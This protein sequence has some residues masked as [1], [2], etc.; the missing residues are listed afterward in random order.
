MRVQHSEPTGIAWRGDGGIVRREAAPQL[1][2]PDAP[3]G[4]SGDQLLHARDHGASP[5]RARVRVADPVLD[6]HARPAGVHAGPLEVRAGQHGARGFGVDERED[7]ARGD[8]RADPA[9][10]RHGL[11]TAAGYVHPAALPARD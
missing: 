11:R 8:P 3:V 2:W 1:G 5:A 6:R 4:S 7:F 9:R 10:L